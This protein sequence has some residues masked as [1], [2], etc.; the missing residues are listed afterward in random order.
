Y[1][2][3]ELKKGKVMKSDLNQLL[4]YVD[5]VSQNYVSNN[6]GMIESFLVGYEFEDELLEEVKKVE[7]DYMKG[8]RPPKFAKWNNI[9]LLKYSYNSEKKILE[10]I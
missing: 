9:K 1:L 8:Y 5:W 7:R 4:K 6:Y 3:V 2:V 10:F